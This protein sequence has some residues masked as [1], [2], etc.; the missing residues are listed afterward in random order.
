MPRP[1]A[2]TVFRF[3]F[4]RSLTLPRL[5]GS[6]LLVLFP[7]ALVALM[8]YQG[9]RFERDQ[10]QA[11]VLFLLIPQ[12]LTMMGLLLWATPIILAELESRTWT[13]LAVRPVGKG[14]VLLGKY[15]TAT[16]WTALVDLVSLTLSMAVIGWGDDSL[17]IWCSLAALI[18]LACLAY[19]ALYV[20]LGVVFLRRAMVAAVAYTFVSDFVL[21]WLPAT[22][23][24]FTVQ[25]HLRCLGAKWMNWTGLPARVGLP[26]ELVFST[27][28]AWQHLAVLLGGTIGVLVIAV[29]VLRRRELIRANET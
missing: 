22:I 4:G 10:R 26:E 21:T 20:L 8:Q 18:P 28:P 13:Y 27:A 2:W 1:A 12:V 24:Q 16:A 29:L 9:A 25:Y 15:I 19:G 23:H 6:C 14:A 5:I 17:R 3:E 7:V 11:L